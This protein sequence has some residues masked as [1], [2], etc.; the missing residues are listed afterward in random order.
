MAIS[1]SSAVGVRVHNLFGHTVASETH[2]RFSNFPRLMNQPIKVLW[3]GFETDTLRL[4]RAGWQLAAEENVERYSIRIAMKHPEL[5]LYGITC[6]FRRDSL[7]DDL[8]RQNTNMILNMQY[9]GHDIKEMSMTNRY[10]FEDFQPINAEPVYGMY[11][12]PTSRSIDDFKLFKPLDKE[13]EI[14]VPSE[15]VAELLDRI[16]KLQ[17]PKQKDIRK[18]KSM[19]MRMT[20][21]D[22]NEYELETELVAQISTL[23]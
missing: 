16:H 23:K 7:E 15:S 20:E 6:E 22:V 4:Q 19:D 11:D 21:K 9:I 13:K 17:E 1:A 8:Y 10:G 2:V 5:K 18:R 3:A 14:I 12:S